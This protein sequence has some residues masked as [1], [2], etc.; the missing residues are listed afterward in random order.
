MIRLSFAATAGAA[1]LTALAFLSIGWGATPIA[2][3]D[4]LAAFARALGLAEAAAATPVDRI[5]IDL[6]TPRA[7]LAILVGSGLGV[8]GCL[9][10]TVTRNDLADPFLFGLS[11]GAALATV[12]GVLIEVPL[13]LMLVRICLKTQ[14]WFAR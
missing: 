11:S 5:V 14:G 4:L 13:M 12:V 6:R 2:L 3:G 8:V 7:L 1:G 9:L 10:Q